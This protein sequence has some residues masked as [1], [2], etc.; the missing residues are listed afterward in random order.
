VHQKLQKK[1]ASLYT[2]INIQESAQT[3]KGRKAWNNIIQALRESNCQP[4]ILYSAKLSFILD[5]EIRTFQDK[6]KPKQFISTK[7][8]DTEGNSS[9]RRG[10]KRITNMRGQERLKLISGIHEAMRH[11][12]ISSMISSVNVQYLKMINAKS[13]NQST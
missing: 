13:T 1:N 11:E 7:T 9:H 6:D 10:R 4:R 2:N 3:L 8:E 12:K 5:G